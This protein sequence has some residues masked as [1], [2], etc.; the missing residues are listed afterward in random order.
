MMKIKRSIVLTIFCLVAWLPVQSEVVHRQFSEDNLLVMVSNDAWQPE[1][2]ENGVTIPA[3][4]TEEA[5]ITIDGRD[6]EPQWQAAK[7]VIVPLEFGYVRQASVK[8]FY[9][10]QEVFIRVRWADSTMDREHHPWV[11]DAESGQ[12]VAGSQVEDSLL[13]SFEAGCEWN[14]SIL[15]GYQFDFDGWQWFAARSDPVGQAWDMVVNLSDANRGGE[16]T[17]Y[18]SRHPENTWILKFDDLPFGSG[19]THGDWN[20]LDRRYLYWPKLPTVSYYPELDRMHVADPSEHIPAPSKPPADESKIFPQFRPVR[21]EGSAGE[22]DAKGHW[23]NGYWTVE[24]RRDLITPDQTLNDTIFNR[25]TQFS[26]HVLDGTER[27]DE[28]SESRRLF[29]Q[30]LPVETHFANK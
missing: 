29:L 3:A 30:F 2:F 14:P 25:L 21:L 26:I 18:Q 7:E 5:G 27:I 17:T 16:G 19:L 6:D 22:V 9:T 24:F 20:D 13:L 23:D 1:N 28:S 15:A 4:R 11:W 8:A 12:Y 10:D